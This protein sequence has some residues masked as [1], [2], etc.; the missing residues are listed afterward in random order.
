[1]RS[2]ALSA[3][4][5]NSAG[6]C[7]VERTRPAIRPRRWFA[8]AIASVPCNWDNYITEYRIHTLLCPCGHPCARRSTD[9][10]CMS[11]LVALLTAGYRVSKRNVQYL[12]GD[13]L[14]RRRSSGGRLFRR[15]GVEARARVIGDV[16]T[17]ISSLSAGDSSGPLR[18]QQLSASSCGQRMGGHIP[19]SS[20]M[21]LFISTISQ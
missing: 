16:F 2:D 3:P 6:T 21:T 15:G 1:M 11:A 14:A 19:Q 8:R 12:L 17:R 5:L 7:D 9:R 18:R 20:L 13:V 4:T 10:G